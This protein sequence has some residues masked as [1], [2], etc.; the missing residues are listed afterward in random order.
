M[1][2]PYYCYINVR[3]KW[4]CDGG[5]LFDTELLTLWRNFT[6]AKKNAWGKKNIATVKPKIDL[7]I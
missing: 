6:T 4:C 5:L 3:C 2:E 1:V 7:H